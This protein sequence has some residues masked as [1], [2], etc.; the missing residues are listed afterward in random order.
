MGTEPDSEDPDPA[1]EGDDSI[2]D[3]LLRALASAPPQTPPPASLASGRYRVLRVLGEGAQKLVLLVEDTVLGRECALSLVRADR[4]EPSGLDRFRREAQ[5]IARLGAHPHV[6]T[7]YDLGEDQGRPYIACEYLSGGD[8]RTTMRESGGSLPLARALAL[9][10]DLC[11]ALVFAHG[12]GLVHRDVKPENVWL[13]ADGTAKLGDFGLALT[14]DRSR[15]SVPGAVVG[16][17]SY[18]APEQAQGQPVD[19]RIDLYALGCVL[20]ELLT[21]RPPFLFRSRSMSTS[22]RCRRASGIPP[23]PRRWIG[24]S[25]GCWRR[26]ATS[27]RH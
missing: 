10:R 23:S 15:L 3:P 11:R 7:I 13:S 6:V 24:S 26:P 25:S 8:L 22:C 16:T 4:L 12:Q 9:A 1:I 17:A 5:A 20:Y 27:A 19:A 2:D 18:L 14:V 21:G